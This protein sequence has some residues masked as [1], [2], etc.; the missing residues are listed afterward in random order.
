MTEIMEYL[1]IPKS[2]EVVPIPGARYA[3][4]PIAF[5]FALICA[6]LLVALM[7][8]WVAGIPVFALILGG[9]FYLVLGTPILLIYLYLRQGTP[10]GAAGLAALTVAIATPLYI[11]FMWFEA[12]WFDPGG[13][14]FLSGA[15]VVHAAAWGLT[16]GKLYNRWRSDVSRR[17]LPQL[18]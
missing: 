4:D 1:E 15:G 3:I 6:P 12:S 13:L 16:F 2:P 5:F 7:F 10:E 18:V 17:P 14:V 11:G 8:F 9:P